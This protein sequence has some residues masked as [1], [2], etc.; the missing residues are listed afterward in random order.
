MNQLFGL[1]HR[2]RTDPEIPS[3]RMIDVETVER[4][5]A[6]KMELSGLRDDG[7]EGMCKAILTRLYTAVDLWRL[8]LPFEKEQLKEWHALFAADFRVNLFLKELKRQNNKEKKAPAPHR[9]EK[10]KKEKVQKTTYTTKEGAANM[11]ARQKA[12]WET[13]LTYE[14]K[15]D[16]EMPAGWPRTTAWISSDIMPHNAS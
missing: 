15:Y 13:L 14:G 10:N 8:L 9:K 2:R 3:M 5:V 6:T 1:Q 16:R 12:F 7:C 4:L 11:E